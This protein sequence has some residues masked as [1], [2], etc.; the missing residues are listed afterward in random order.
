M[1][2]GTRAFP[3]SCGFDGQEGIRDSPRPRVFLARMPSGVPSSDS[4]P[5][6]DREGGSAAGG[7]G[8]PNQAPAG[9]KIIV[10]SF[11]QISTHRHLAPATRLMPSPLRGATLTAA[12]GRDNDS[13]RHP[14]ARPNRTG[15]GNRNDRTGG[16]HATPCDS[17][18]RSPQT[19]T[20]VPETGI[21]GCTR[22]QHRDQCR[23]RGSFVA[24]RH[25]GVDARGP[26][27]REI[28]GQQGHGA[29][30]EYAH[31]EDQRVGAVHLEEQA[32]QHLSY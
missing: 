21:R 6:P 32:G 3:S 10:H 30:Q 20:I 1:L 11:F 28:A 23:P 26:A 16:K 5:P 31:R 8:K 4:P 18:N 12:P 13:D 27:R 25:H 9:A 29:Q 7:V 22:D 19:G 15:C 14:P 17:T 24:E 2:P